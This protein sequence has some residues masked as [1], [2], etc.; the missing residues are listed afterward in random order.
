MK[1]HVFY[2]MINQTVKS[3]MLL[4]KTTEERDIIFLILSRYPDDRIRELNNDIKID[5]LFTGLLKELDRQ[6]TR[7]N[8]DIANEKL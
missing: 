2:P 7:W 1:S 3:F 5:P 8:K 6:F 4:A